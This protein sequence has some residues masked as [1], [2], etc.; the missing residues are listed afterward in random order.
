MIVVRAPSNIA[1]IKYMGKLTTPEAKGLNIPEN[2]SLSMTLHDLCTFAEAVWEPGASADIAWLPESPRLAAL[3]RHARVP[4]LDAAGTEKVARHARR[5]LAAAPE[6]LARLGVA[7]RRGVSAGLVLRTA[8]TFP[9]ASGIASSASAFAALTLAVTAAAAEDS[10][11]FAR[12]YEAAGVGAR[13]AL[14]GLARQGSGSA[15]RSFEGPF[16]EWQ[17]TET[18]TVPSE[19]PKLAHFVLVVSD[20]A[21]QVSSSEAHLKVKTSP[22]WQGRIE[23]AEAKLVDVR[24]ALAAGDLK[25]LAWITW[26]EAW[27][28]HSLFHTCEEPFTYWEPT[29]IQV[30]KKLAPTLHESHPPIVTLDAGPNI[31]VIVEAD[32]AAEWKVRF[33]RDFAGLGLLED[34]PGAGAELIGF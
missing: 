34:R 7:P 24:R 15:C 11:A 33:A 13:R 30:L 32:R 29:T 3:P 6:F 23:R 5:V 25:S 19:L 26:R 2:S 20:G 4:R 28:M 10:A 18:R 21:K 31:H 22:L 16:V 17:Q 1:L 27:E 12:A 14:A 9:E 8:N